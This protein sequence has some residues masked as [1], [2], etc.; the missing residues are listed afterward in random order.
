[1][2]PLNLNGAAASEVLIARVALA[3]ITQEAVK[4]VDGSE[5]G[6]V[7]LGHDVEKLVVQFAGGPGP[8]A[9]HRPD[10]FHR[11][12]RHAQDLASVA[13]QEDRS[14][15]IGEWHTHPSGVLE[16]SQTDLRSYLRHLH[17]P[18]LRLER[19]L[20]VIVSVDE[21]G[22]QAVAWVVQP[23]ATYLVPLRVKEEE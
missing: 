4:S 23:S 9:V 22:V 1:M 6:G 18:E 14:Q 11:D 10:R 5:T 16:P 20:S 2:Q 17:D 21:S 8:N 15:W 19:F 12:L 3:V 13:W 7:L